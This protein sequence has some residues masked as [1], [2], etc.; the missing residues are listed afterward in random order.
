MRE[1]L[2]QRRVAWP[3]RKE[4]WPLPRSDDT[5]KSMCVWLKTSV[6]QVLRKMMMC[7]ID[8][9]RQPCDW[10]QACNLWLGRTIV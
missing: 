5:H 6:L 3:L 2:P 1:V 9:F 8:G 10:A 7:P 4:A